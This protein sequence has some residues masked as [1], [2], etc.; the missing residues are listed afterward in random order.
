MN[1]QE[2]ILKIKSSGDTRT[3]A[4]IGKE[5]DKIVADTTPAVDPNIIV[6]EHIAPQSNTY[7]RVRADGKISTGSANAD[8]T[9][10][11]SNFKAAK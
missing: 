4:A 10:S 9:I 6:S 2:Y 7:E 5:Y 8:G 11:W 3:V 1:K